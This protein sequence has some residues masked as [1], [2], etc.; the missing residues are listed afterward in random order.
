MIYIYK[1]L[2]VGLRIGCQG[3]RWKQ[4]DLLG[5]VAVIQMRVGGGMGKDGN[6]DT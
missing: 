6:T 3:T 1:D 5:G 2:T 4:G